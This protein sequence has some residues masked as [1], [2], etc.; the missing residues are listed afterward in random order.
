V[1]EP[2]DPGRPVAAE[3]ETAALRRLQ[4]AMGEAQ[5]ALGRRMRMIPSDLAAM[6]HLA[7]ASEALGPTDLS[8][9]LGLSPGATT[10]LVDRLERAG[11]LLRQRDLAD[12]RRV[13]LVPSESARG[14]VVGRLGA[15]IEALDTIA[16]DFTDDERDVVRRYLERATQAYRDYAGEEPGG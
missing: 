15:L 13:R 2:S 4:V 1:D 5:L 12:R 8:V 3:P 6:A 11:H 10:E 7:A 14:E 9:R 16:E